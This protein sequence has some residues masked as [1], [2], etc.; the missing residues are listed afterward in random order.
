MEI[1]YAFTFELLPTA[2]VTIFEAGQWPSDGRLSEIAVDRLKK[3]VKQTQ[4]D[5][6]DSQ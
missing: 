2:P 1:F 4:I 3:H 6:S 5:S